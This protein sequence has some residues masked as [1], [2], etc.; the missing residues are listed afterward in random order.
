MFSFLHLKN[1]LNNPQKYF[2][3]TGKDNNKPAQ[4]ANLFAKLAKNGSELK[5]MFIF[6]RYLLIHINHN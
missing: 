4:P 1:R 2:K 6:D 5:K 3:K